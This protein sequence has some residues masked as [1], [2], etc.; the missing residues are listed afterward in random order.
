MTADMPFPQSPT[1]YKWVEKHPPP[2]EILRLWTEVGNG[3]DKSQTGELSS[4]KL[5][6]ILARSPGVEIFSIC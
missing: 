1:P 3:L 4:P 2:P 6:V 5:G